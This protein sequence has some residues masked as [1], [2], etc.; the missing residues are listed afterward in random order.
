MEVTVP[1]EYL[2]F[3]IE[4]PICAV[5]ALT[6]ANPTNRYEISGY[7]HP[8]IPLTITHAS[9]TVLTTKNFDYFKSIS[10]KRQH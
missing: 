1:G 7:E 8:T 5:N 10:S 3:T 2:R 9:T 4:A 6:N